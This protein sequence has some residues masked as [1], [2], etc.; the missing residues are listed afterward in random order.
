MPYSGPCAV[1]CFVAAVQCLNTSMLLVLQMGSLDS[2]SLAVVPH[3]DLFG[4][5]GT[6]CTAP[7]RF[8]AHAGNRLNDCMH[9]P[10][11]SSRIILLNESDLN[12]LSRFLGRRLC[13]LCAQV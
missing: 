7:W 5:S 13:I 2:I 9:V 11:S 10:L 8:L 1:V 3:V 6:V 12:A 4:T